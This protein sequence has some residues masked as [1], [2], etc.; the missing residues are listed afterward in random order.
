MYKR[1]SQIIWHKE[2]LKIIGVF[3]LI[4]SP[5]L[6][7][8]TL[9]D[10]VDLW[11]NYGFLFT[12]SFAQFR[13]YFPRW[14]GVLFVFSRLAYA[15]PM[16][17]GIGV[18]Y[19]VQKCV[20][21]KKIRLVDFA[22][23]IIAG[24]IVLYGLSY[25]T[26][27]FPLISSST[28]SMLQIFMSRIYLGIGGI[29]LLLLVKDAH[30]LRRFTSWIFQPIGPESLWI[31]HR[32]FVLYSIYLFFLAWNL[33]GREYL[34]QQE[35]VP[36]P[37]FGWLY[38]FIPVSNNLYMISIG[39]GVLAAILTLFR[40]WSKAAM[41]VLAVALTYVVMVPNFY[42]KLW[43]TQIII[44][45]VWILVFV[46]RELLDGSWKA[47]RLSKVKRPEY[48]FYIR[49]L[50]LLFGHIYFFA[51]F[52]KL[53]TCGLEWA[54]GDN[55]IALFQMEWF[56]HY[57]RLPWLRI[58]RLSWLLHVGGV[59]TILLELSY[60]FWLIQD[61][62]RFISIG[63]GLFLHAFAGMFL[64]IGFFWFLVVY[65]V[66]YIPWNI[67]FDKGRTEVEGLP[68][69]LRSV[70]YVI[71]LTILGI[72]L[73]FGALKID[74]YPFSIYPVY[75]DMP[76]SSV[77]Y[78]EFEL[79]T[80]TDDTLYAHK[81][82]ERVGF[83]WENYS[84]IDYRLLS[85]YQNNTSSPLDT[86]GILSQWERWKNGVSSLYKPGIVNV[87]VAC[88]PLDPDLA[89]EKTGQYVFSFD[90]TTEKLCLQP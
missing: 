69:N 35:Y 16:M 68:K 18:V 55:F 72:N 51:G 61:R 70:G 58:D 9:V 39:V 14:Y 17:F 25:Y 7:S 88:R 19:V 40:A 87:Y 63:G 5:L 4:G 59:F 77:Y 47:I 48:G 34:G 67:I 22:T 49:I 33:P 29:L 82:G 10:V 37:I 13:G 71:P 79:H 20:N 26:L 54:I 74:S 89:H 3:I 86:A 23:W 66:V 52:Y 30:Y 53:W 90:N 24:F 84:R 41:I 36:L 6:I 44:W 65:Y 75:T 81:E 15:L 32:F 83:R 62:F 38:R 80:N 2:A 64:Y 56:E 28:A 8:L 45:H 85:S 31:Y 57:D 76:A 27:H 11:K 42:G 78:F 73:L 60:P 12:D 1:L 21:K 43:H 50:W 46:P